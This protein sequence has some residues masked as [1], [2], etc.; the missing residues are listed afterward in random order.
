MRIMGLDFGTVTC[1]VALSDELLL[2]AQPLETIRRKHANKLRQTL[3]R[4]EE[5]IV[6]YKVERIVLGLPLNL[7]GDEGS[8][9]AACRDFMEALERRTGLEVIMQDERL[10]TV[11]AHRVLD[12]AGL[13]HEDK[14]KVVDKIAAAII[15]QSY[16]DSIYNQKDR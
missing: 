3:A 7:S 13:D 16:L 9:A 6:Q 4:I 14:N 2:T 15:L 5:L 10:S 1:G 11:E 12:E 8:R